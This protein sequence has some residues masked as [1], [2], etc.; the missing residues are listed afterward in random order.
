LF[1]VQLYV[2]CKDPTTLAATTNNGELTVVVVVKPV[3]II[4]PEAGEVNVGALK[5]V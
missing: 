4:A 3:V 1:D 2:F 5:V